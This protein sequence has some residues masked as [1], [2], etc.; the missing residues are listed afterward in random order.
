MTTPADRYVETNGLTLHHRDWGGEGRAVVLLH[1]LA[2]NARI[3][4]L[5][6]PLLAQHA[7]VL[8]FDQRGHG[9]SDKPESGYGFDDITADIAGAI[10]ALG[11]E[12]PVVIGHSWGGNVAPMLAVRYPDRVGAIGMVDGGVFE[13]SK[14][15]TWERAEEVMAPPRLAGTPRAKFLEMI[16]GHEVSRMWTPEI[17]AA[18]MGNFEIREDDTIAPWL[19]FERHMMILRAIYGYHPQEVLPHVQ[20]PALIMPCIGDPASEAAQ[21]KREAVARVE[22]L[23]PHGRTHWFE[24]AIHDVPLQKPA[25]VAAAIQSLLDD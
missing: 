16:R 25:E 21:R 11:L 6:A 13:L 22:S 17:E 8:A 7:R 1:G 4:D 5:T 15:M 20:C 19:T 3:W 9:L 10:D 12:A 14:D 24:S 18:I 23:L 2:S